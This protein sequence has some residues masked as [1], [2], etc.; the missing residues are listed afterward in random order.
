MPLSVHGRPLRAVLSEQNRS[1]R[2]ASLMRWLGTFRL[3]ACPVVFLC[4]FQAAHAQRSVSV[5]WDASPDT[6]VT[7]YIVRYGFRSR[8]YSKSLQTGGKTTA[9]LSGLRDGLGYFITVAAVNA[10]G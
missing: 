7:D 3:F 5:A 2:A 8:V 4:A 9:T 1:V 10:F 6:N